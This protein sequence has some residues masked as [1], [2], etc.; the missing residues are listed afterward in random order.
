[1]RSHSVT[2][3]MTPRQAVEAMRALERI[4]ATTDNERAFTARHRIM[5]GLRDAGWQWDEFNDECWRLAGNVIKD[6]VDQ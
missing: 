5:S 4:G 6:R 1:M 3:R 2:V